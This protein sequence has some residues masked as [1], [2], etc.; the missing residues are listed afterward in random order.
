MLYITLCKSRGK[1]KSCNG[2][3]WK[4][5]FICIM[6]LSE[7]NWV[8]TLFIWI[9][10]ALWSMTWKHQ[11]ILSFAIIHNLLNF[12]YINDL[13]HFSGNCCIL[14]KG[15]I[16][17]HKRKIEMMNVHVLMTNIPLNLVMERYLINSL[18]FLTILFR[19]L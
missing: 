4:S 15:R 3:R 12:C 13:V 2:N 1:K 19:I 16:E 6:S 9:I 11:V 14:D 5:M 8:V 17:D 18:I 7:K 10:W